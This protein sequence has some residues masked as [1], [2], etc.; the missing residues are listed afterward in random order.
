MIEDR[1]S[2]EDLLLAT[3]DAVSRFRVLA[4]YL[5]EW[6]SVVSVGKTRIPRN[7]HAFIRREIR[8]EGVGEKPGMDPRDLI[9]I[10]ESL[11]E[12]SR[13]GTSRGSSGPRRPAPGSLRSRTPHLAG[14]VAVD[15]C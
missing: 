12:G 4:V 7:S 14:V 13:C 1:L 11:A 6:L 2:L 5:M 8:V 3:L 15:R 9:R 10:A